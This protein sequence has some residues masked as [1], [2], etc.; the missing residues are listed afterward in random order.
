LESLAVIFEQYF[1]KVGIATPIKR[2]AVFCEWKEIVGTRVASVTE[3]ARISGER[4]FIKVKSDVWR[5]ELIFHKA[6]I[7]KKI[8]QRAGEETIKDIVLI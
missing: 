8:N 6:D 4:L 7:L 1:R 3:P 2:Y 5:N